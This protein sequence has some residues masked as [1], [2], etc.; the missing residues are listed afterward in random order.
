[1]EMIYFISSFCC[2][3]Y[4]WLVNKYLKMPLMNVTIN[5]LKYGQVKYNLTLNGLRHIDEHTYT[6]THTHT[7]T[8]TII[9][10]H[11]GVKM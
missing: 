2:C 6:H 10:L 7:R 11:P 8:H 9:L 4:Q 5:A 1:M 3:Q